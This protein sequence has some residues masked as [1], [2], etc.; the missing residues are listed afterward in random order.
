MEIMMAGLPENICLIT[1]QPVESVIETC[2]SLRTA[3]SQ[4]AR[5]EATES[6]DDPKGAPGVA[7]ETCEEA[8]AGAIIL[9]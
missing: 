2:G 7:T 3:L 9:A 4:K 5:A 8:G 1:F 6:C